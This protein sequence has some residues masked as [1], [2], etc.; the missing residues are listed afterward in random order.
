MN[1]LRMTKHQINDEFIDLTWLPFT[2]ERAKQLLA[3]ETPLYK[4]FQGTLSGIVKFS[5]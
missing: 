4:G 3:V 5:S 1:Q 2:K